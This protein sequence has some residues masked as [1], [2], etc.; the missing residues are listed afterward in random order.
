ML[1]IG[2]DVGTQGARVVACDLQGT[3]VAHAEQSFPLPQ[4]KTPVIGWSE[5]D[6]HVWWEATVACLQR[7]SASLLQEGRASWP[8]AGLSVTSTS[9]TVCLVDA[10]GEPLGPALMYN[11]QR[12]QVEAEEV[13]E[14]GSALAEKL[15]YRFSS[16]FALCKLLWL[17]RHC[18]ER[19]AAARLFLSPTDFIV[20]CLSG[21]FDVTDYSNALKTGYD[22][23]ERSWPG[24]IEDKLGIPCDRLPHV[25]APGTPVGEVTSQVERLTGI[26][27]GTPVIAGMTDGCASQISTGAVAPGQWNSTL[28]TT[29]VLKG[30]TRTLVRDPLGRIYCHRHPDGYWLPGGASNTGGEW[31][32]QRFEPSELDQLNALALECAP[33]GLVIYPL[34]RLGERFPFVCPQAQGFI[35]GDP[36]TNRAVLYT[37]AL[38]GVGYVERLAYEVVE[39]LGAEVGDRVYVAGGS[40]NSQAWLQVRADILGKTLLVPRASGGAMGAA[41]VAAGGTVYPGIVAAAQAMVSIVQQ[42]EPRSRLRR[43]Y[44]ERYMCF[45][46][47]CIV[48]GYLS[49]EEGRR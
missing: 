19:F 12:A 30:V 48:R 1:V 41:I 16:S 21:R 43:V 49:P 45:R 38:E 39:G 22:L 31:I 2:I 27:A 46:D 5:Q 40:T 26:P 47:A 35:L 11:D 3:I 23:L 20:G 42:V 13:N 18:P 6:P 29:L 34:A 28:G 9:G 17:K 14:V 24:F 10:H 7:V 32:A 4:T 33:T 25:V 36:S 15:G 8:I 37:A 44:D